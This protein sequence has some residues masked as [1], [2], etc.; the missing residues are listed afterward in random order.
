MKGCSVSRRTVGVVAVAL[1]AASLRVSAA[2]DLIPPT[3]DLAG[4]D[5][6]P[7]TLS[8]VSEPPGLQA[9][10]DGVEIGLTPVWRKQ[11]DPGCH[12]VRMADAESA[13]CVDPGQ[14]SMLSYFKDSFVV[15][16]KA[17]KA[18]EQTAPQPIAPKP[19]E[20]HPRPRETG[21]RGEVS[22][23]ERFLIGVSPTF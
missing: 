10:L 20:S 13:I 5:Q 15:I 12:A 3:R 22:P 19:T 14:D 6:R 7:A 9:F 8:V 18:V 11:V 1:V 4:S 21:D 23:W 2:D 16:P 17:R